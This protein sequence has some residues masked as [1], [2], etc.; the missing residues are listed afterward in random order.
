MIPDEKL[1][2]YLDA[3]K[4]ADLEAL[5]NSKF[6]V[7]NDLEAELIEVK[8]AIDLPHQES[9]SLLFL[10]PLDFPAQ[11]GNYVFE[12]PQVGAHEIFVVPIE[13]AS[14]GI[15]FQAVFNRLRPKS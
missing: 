12:H 8:D 13:K 3:I 9:F 15:V 2:E 1:R 7:N 14:D 6:K 10:L 5:I 11:Q 4:R